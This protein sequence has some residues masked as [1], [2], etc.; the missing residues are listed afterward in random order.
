MIFDNKTADSSSHHFKNMFRQVDPAIH[1][2]GRTKTCNSE[3][4][5][6]ITSR[7]QDSIRAI[8]VVQRSLNSCL[9]N[10]NTLV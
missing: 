1:V 10:K 7:K 4:S 5:S 2:H 3:I 9:P 8:D 6:G